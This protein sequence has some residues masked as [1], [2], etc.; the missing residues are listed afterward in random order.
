[1]DG[2]N[3]KIKILQHIIIRPVEVDDIE[4]EELLQADMT[5]EDIA[6][7]MLDVV[8]PQS[9]NNENEDVWKIVEELEENMEASKKYE[10]NQSEVE[11]WG[12]EEEWNFDEVLVVE[13]M[14]KREDKQNEVEVWGDEEEWN[15][16]EVLVVEE[17]GRRVCEL[18]REIEEHLQEIKKRQEIV[19]RLQKERDSILRL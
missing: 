7:A 14:K 2:Q 10:K 1:M 15:L 4:M 5:E 3:S 17:K 6:A 12:D 18:E 8:T 16:E 9:V 13:E 11:L 19:K